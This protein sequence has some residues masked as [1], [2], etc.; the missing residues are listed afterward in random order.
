MTAICNLLS[1][2]FNTTGLILQRISI[3]VSLFNKPS[4]KHSINFIQ[5]LYWPYSFTYTIYDDDMFQP[6]Q[7]SSSGLPCM[8][9]MD[10]VYNKAYKNVTILS[11]WRWF[12]IIQGIVYF[13]LQYKYTCGT[14]S[15]GHNTLIKWLHI[16]SC[17]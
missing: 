15:S 13:G 11:G 5:A 3:L 12:Y 9:W 8:Y 4:G 17:P 6:I 7:G 16:I 1:V 2:S 14:Y 10:N